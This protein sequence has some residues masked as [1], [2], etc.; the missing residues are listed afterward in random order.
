MGIL[1]CCFL[2]ILICQ[3]LCIVSYCLQ[4]FTSS[5][6]LDFFDVNNAS[7]NKF[8]MERISPDVFKVTSILNNVTASR[9]A[10]R[11]K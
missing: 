4:E 5:D 9:I 10:K 2:Y 7:G 3:F 8:I 1:N 6:K 11:V